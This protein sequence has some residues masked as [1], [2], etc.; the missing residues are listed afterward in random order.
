MDRTHRHHEGFNRVD[1]PRRYGL[2]IRDD[3]GRRV[4]GVDGLMW[5]GSVSPWAT[6]SYLESPRR[7]HDCALPDCERCR[8]II[9]EDMQPENIFHLRI[10]QGPVINH[11]LSSS[12]KISGF[13]CGLEE[14]LD[15]P[16]QLLPVLG[17]YHRRP[18]EHGHMCIMPTGMHYSP[19]P[20]LEINARCLVEGERIHVSPEPHHVPLVG[21][22]QETY[23]PLATDIGPYS[24]AQRPESFGHE[25]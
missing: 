24:D 10:F 21:P 6:Y 2:D 17:K 18:Q 14:K 15:G 9:R 19:F 23:H 1:H 12:A 25:P 20:R 7:C 3:L 13:F 5:S 8:R 16:L 11:R 4:N 22:L